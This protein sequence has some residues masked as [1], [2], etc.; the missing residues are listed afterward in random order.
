MISDNVIMRTI[1]DIPENHLAALGAWCEREGI[2]RAEAIRR[3]LDAVLPGKQAG[4]RA[5]SFGAWK[6]RKNS[7]ALV[8][9]M[10]EEWA[11]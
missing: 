3:A 7:R 10:R 9:A 6:P 11:R 2:S 8:G 5:E 4:R 1:V